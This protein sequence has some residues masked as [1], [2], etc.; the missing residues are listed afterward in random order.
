MNQLPPD[1]EFQSAIK[2]TMLAD[3]HWL[4]ANMRRL[5]S[6][7]KSGNAGEP[8]EPNH[9]LEGFLKRFEGS[10]ERFAQR[11]KSLP[12]P[13]LD[14]TLP[15]AIRS[16]EITKAMLD[17]QV[18]VISG[19]TGSGKSTQLPLIALRAGIG[20]RGMIGHTQP[21]RIAA[22]GVAARLAS[23]IGTPMGKD[24]G[25]KIRFDDKTGNDTFV[26]LTVSYTHLTLPTTPY[27]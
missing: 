9:K 13:E 23:Q 19:E 6:Q 7:L 20:V 16:E 21:R 18:V 5:K 17:N 3:E 10:R 11:Q 24:V 22:R 1:P 4:R 25:F 26:K 27:V 14:E 2:Q 15:I 8:E 12:K